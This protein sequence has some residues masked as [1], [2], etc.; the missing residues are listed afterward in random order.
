MFRGGGPDETLKQPSKPKGRRRDIAMKGGR[1]SLA[2]IGACILDGG[3]MTTRSASPQGFMPPR[4][5][6][7]GE[8]LAGALCI[9]LLCGAFIA[10]ATVTVACAGFSSCNAGAELT[11]TA[12]PLPSL[13]NSGTAS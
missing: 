8:A 10:S 5:A 12:A 13:A 3:H 2:S 11:Q 1:P 4:R 9:L 6:T 7:R